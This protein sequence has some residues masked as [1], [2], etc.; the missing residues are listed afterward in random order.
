MKVP[1]FRSKNTR[2]S[3]RRGSALDNIASGSEESSPYSTAPS[4][5]ANMSMPALPRFTSTAPN[6][7]TSNS[8]GS[9]VAQLAEMEEFLGK[10][11][12]FQGEARRL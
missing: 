5:S 7:A 1:F 4:S 3:S 11:A 6:N 9:I 10:I 8:S 2:S 12:D